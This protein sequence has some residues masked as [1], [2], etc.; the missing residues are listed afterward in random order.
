MERADFVVIG[1]GIAG[2]SAAYELAAHG[3]VVLLEAEAT[4][5]YHTTGRS[6]ALF[7]EAYEKDLVRLLTVAS[8]EFL[9]EPPPG[10]AD[11]PI[12]SPLPTMM[13]GRADQQGRVDEEVEAARALVP[14]VQALD[15]SAAVEL[16]PILRPGYVAAALYEPDSR[17]IDVHALHQGFLGTLQKRDG[18]A[19]VSSRVSE[20][21]RS[22]GT[23]TVIAGGS[24]VVAPVVVNAAGAWAD[25]VAKLA[26]ARPLGL[27]PKRR[28][29][30][31]FAAPD[32]V[33]TASLPM[34]IDIE[35]DFYF[36]PEGPQ[37]LGSLAEET[38]MEPHDVRPEEVD[39][40]LAIERIESATTLSIRHVRTAWAG[41]RT[42]APDRLPVVGED[43]AASGFFWLAGQGGYGIMTSPG[44]S[45]ALAGLVVD[46]ELPADLVDL[47]VRA[48]ALSPARF[49]G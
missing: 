18:N 42:F 49:S 4:C 19:L 3:N 27:G 38:P 6:A 8:R 7:T 26:G 35:E 12:L 1:G 23:W 47:G 48:E 29:A 45:R 41:L 15:E 16:C 20:L 43:P 31:T 33:E 44:M 40:A 39:V 22:R 14:S 2:A 5:G 17:S 13:I 9:E 46:G 28:T 25:A 30:F 10:F 37:F 11:T 24:V 32:G 34:V 36:K 21:A